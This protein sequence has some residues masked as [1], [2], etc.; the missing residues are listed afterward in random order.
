[1]KG[2]TSVLLKTTT[3]HH[4]VN[5]AHAS[6]PYNTCTSAFPKTTLH[7][8]TNLTHVNFPYGT[9]TSAFLETTLHHE[10]NLAHASFLSI[11][12]T[13]PFPKKNCTMNKRYH[14][15]AFPMAQAQVHCK[16]QHCTMKEI[17]HALAFLPL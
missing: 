14:L 8:E 9:S 5:L 12:T 3:L 11:I 13:N 10:G 4:E 17:E 2:N 16:I 6:F 15:L 7:Y 1:M